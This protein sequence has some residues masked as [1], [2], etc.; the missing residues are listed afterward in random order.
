MYVKNKDAET[1][2]IV[3]VYVRNGERIPDNY[4]REFLDVIG[5]IVEEKEKERKKIREYVAEKRKENPDY[6]RPKREWRK[7][8][9]PHCGR[10]VAPSDNPDYVWQCFHC[11]EDFYDFE[12][13]K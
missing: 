9:C 5:R 7:R 12:V 13:V 3:S 8:R 6:G 10:V 4:K 1:L 2:L 11:E